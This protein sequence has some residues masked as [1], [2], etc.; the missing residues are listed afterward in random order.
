MC[1]R[2]PLWVISGH[3]ATRQQCPLYVRANVRL[4]PKADILPFVRLA[5]ESSV[6]RVLKAKVFLTG[7]N[8]RTKRGV[9]SGN[10]PRTQRKRESKREL[11][12]RQERIAGVMRSKL[13]ATG[14]GFYL[15]AVVCASIYPAFDRSTFS[16]I[17]VVLLALPWIDY[18][19][20]AWLPLAIMLNAV[21]IFGLLAVLALV[22][23][24]LRR[25][26]K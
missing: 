17:I 10:E 20:S 26:R 12:K 5:R 15:L 19:P 16:G 21:I 14:T 2:F 8:Y 13:A 4:V 11:M 9:N 3:F 18:L 25:L 1:R 7:M 22:P 6:R 24:V 23:T